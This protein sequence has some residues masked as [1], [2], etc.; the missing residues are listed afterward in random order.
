MSITQLAYTPCRV[1]EIMTPNVLTVDENDSLWDAWQMMFISGHRHL[2]VLS[3]NQCIGIIADR[4]IL[5]SV[6]VT[7][8]RLVKHKVTDLMNRAQILFALPT[9]PIH[10]AATVM[11]EYKVNALPVLDEKRHLRGLITSTDLISWIAQ[12]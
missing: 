3:D 4:S 7:E 12:R 2:A 8:A 11:A 9:T 5:S 10:A 1:E 6:I